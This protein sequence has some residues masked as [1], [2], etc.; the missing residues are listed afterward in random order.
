MIN[1]ARPCIMCGKL[2]EC[3]VDTWD[4]NQPY[5]GGEMQL[6]FAY[7]SCK[8]DNSINSTVHT[9][10]ICDGCGT[11]LIERDTLRDLKRWTKDLSGEAPK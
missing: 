2:M 9:F 11:T 10:L 3:A 5:G 6:I 1:E 4:T 8:H 7:G